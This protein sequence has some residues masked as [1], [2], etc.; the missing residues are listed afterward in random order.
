MK[1]MFIH[2]GLPKTATTFLQTKI[3]PYFSNTVLLSRPYT[4]QNKAFNQLQYADDCYYNS[5]TIKQEIAELSASNILISDEGLCGLSV[6][7]K[8]VV[9]RSLIARRFQEIFPNAEI[10]LFLRGQES[11]LASAYNQAVKMGY[12]ETIQQYIWYPQKEYTYNNYQKDLATNQFRWNKNTR[13]YNFLS[14]HIHLID[15][16]YYELIKIYK[17]HFSNVH[18]FLYEHLCQDPQA[19]IKELENILKDKITNAESHLLS[20]KVNVKF[21]GD[22]LKRT[23]AINKIKM[24]VKTNNKYILSAGGLIYRLVNNERRQSCHSELEYIAKVTQS[25]YAIN[26]QKIV[27]EYPSIG[28]QNYPE[29]YQL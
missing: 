17:D 19:V 21:D 11:L 16:Y 20:E 15:L 13:Y 10:I 27:S 14:S 28:L 6:L 25:F 23:R 4:Q 8:S 29:Q 12:A 1:K 9:N 3:F 2:I 22:K 24:I 7:G 26:N 18:V 5:E